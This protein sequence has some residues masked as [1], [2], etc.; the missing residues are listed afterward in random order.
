MTLVEIIVGLISL[1]F[2]GGGAA[3]W[4]TVRPRP[5][6]LALVVQAEQI[7]ILTAETQRLA[8]RLEIESKLEPEFRSSKIPSAPTIPHIPQHSMSMDQAIRFVDAQIEKAKNPP[9]Y[10]W[11]DQ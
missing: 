9:L 5:S 11:M 3:A 6:K 4:L 2:A 10:R 7:K 1:V 8:R